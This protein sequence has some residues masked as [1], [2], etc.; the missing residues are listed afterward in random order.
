[1]DRV[2]FGSPGGDYALEIGSF[3]SMQVGRGAHSSL[4]VKPTFPQPT[5]PTDGPMD[6]PGTLME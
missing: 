3:F 6:L 2:S 1:V 4:D 5:E